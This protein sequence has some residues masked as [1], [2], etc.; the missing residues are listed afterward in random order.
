MAASLFHQGDVEIETKD[1]QTHRWKLYRQGTKQKRKKCRHPPLNECVRFMTHGCLCIM[2][3]FDMLPLESRTH[4]GPLQ[5]YYFGEPS[6]SLETK[7]RPKEI[8][9]F[10][11][12]PHPHTLHTG[13][14]LIA[15]SPPEECVSTHAL[16][17]TFFFQHRERFLKLNS[18]QQQRAFALL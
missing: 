15:T 12:N 4:Q 18:E 3:T 14:L 1:R 11:T 10:P 16:K 13:E 6:K 9:D 2:F 7:R 5:Q 8:Q 17:N